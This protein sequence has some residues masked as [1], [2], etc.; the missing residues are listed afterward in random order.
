MR[1]RK[2]KWAIPFLENSQY[3]TCC[4]SDKPLL[5]EK[6]S[7]DI[8][9]HL[10]I[11]VGKGDFI[12][13]MAGMNPN[14]NFVGIETHPSV[15]AICAK[16]VEDLQL[17]NVHLFFIDGENLLE[18]INKDSIECLY[19]NFS[20]PW[21]KARHTKRRLTSSSFIE[22]YE[23][24][25]KKNAIIKLKTDNLG[26]YNYSLESLI[27]HNYKIIANETDYQLTD[28]DASSE[29]EQKFRNLGMPIYR[30]IAKRGN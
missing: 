4:K 8:P 16:K 20:D 15:L 17:S 25:L 21:P 12:T 19:L 5:L 27:E 11:G 9:I 22:K 1:Q 13:K 28:D 26:F 10:E 29:Y 6:L 30:I 18:V 24:I 7:K 23:I 2:L 14:I 3:V